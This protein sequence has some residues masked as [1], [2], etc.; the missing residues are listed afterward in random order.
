MHDENLSDR[1]AK[2]VAT[3]L[4][5]RPFSTVSATLLIAE[6]D[7]TWQK[8]S[9]GG[10][11]LWY[12]A[13]VVKLACR[14]AV[15]ALIR[16]RGGEGAFSP[17]L[18]KDMESTYGPSENPPFGRV[19]DELTETSNYQPLPGESALFEQWRGNRLVFERYLDSLGLLRGQRF[20]MKTYPGNTSEAPEGAEGLLMGW[21][22]GNRLRTDDLADL[23][24]ALVESRIEPES[25]ELI[26]RLLKRERWADASV[27]GHGLPP[28]SRYYGKLGCGYDTEGDTAYVV[29]PNGRRFVLSLFA[30]S[31]VEPYVEDGHFAEQAIIGPLVDAIITEFKLYTEP[32]RAEVAVGDSNWTAT[33]EWDETATASL[34]TAWRIADGSGAR[35]EFRLTIEQAGTYELSYAYGHGTAGTSTAKMLLR[36][37]SGNAPETILVDDYLDLSRVGDRWFRHGE[38]ELVPGDHVLRIVDYIGDPRGRSIG[39]AAVRLRW[40]DVPT[41]PEP[42]N[43]GSIPSGNP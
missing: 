43:A 15:A 8:A 29:L 36:G 41:A 13:C 10:R 25:R 16:E 24:L 4:K 3:Y 38:F 32:A 35:Q 21:Y 6:D 19:L 18:W 1:L 26:H 23:M 42:P 30:D 22:G 20:V 14:P 12:P 5:G 37:P 7:G 33:G 11:E 2:A 31:R 17:E 27:I 9:H 34:R 28:G 40:I 39:M